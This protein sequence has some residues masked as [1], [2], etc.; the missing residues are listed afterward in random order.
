MSSLVNL[1]L[2]STDKNYEYINGMHCWEIP[3]QL[4]KRFVGLS[5]AS[6]IFRK[7]APQRVE[8]TSNIVERNL[9]NS[10]GILDIITHPFA[11]QHFGKMS[12]G[13][14]NIIVAVK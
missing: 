11:D 14:S 5:V 13:I 8:I 6:C 4:E 3:I 10:R 7:D 9:E 1:W 12:T 2:T